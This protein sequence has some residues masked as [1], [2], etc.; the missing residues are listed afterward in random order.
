LKTALAISA[1]TVKGE[2]LMEEQVHPEQLIDRVT[3]LKV[4]PLPDLMKWK[5]M[6]LAPH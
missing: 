6:G 2:M 4:A 5:C 3:T 1:Q